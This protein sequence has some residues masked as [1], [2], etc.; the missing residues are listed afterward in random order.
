MTSECRFTQGM[1]LKCTCQ[2]GISE[3][4]PHSG[5][6]MGMPPPLSATSRGTMHIGSVN[7]G[8]FRS[9]LNG[10]PASGSAENNRQQHG[11][12]IGWIAVCKHIDWLKVSS[13]GHVGNDWGPPP[14]RT[15]INPTVAVTL[16]TIPVHS[17]EDLYTLEIAYSTIRRIK[18]INIS[19][20]YW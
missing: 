10:S 18:V 8:G 11:G 3:S 6:P 5:G 15:V 2:T 17:T 7:I 19:L 13:V 14:P 4:G 9:H 12:G 1:H 20:M 16:R